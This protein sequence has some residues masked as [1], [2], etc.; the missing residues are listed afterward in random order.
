MSDPLL[1]QSVTAL[2]DERP[3]LEDFFAALGLSPPGNGTPL[4]RFLRQVPAERLAEFSLDHDQ[5]IAQCLAFIERME[6][7]GNER[8]E[9]VRRVTVKAGLD[10]DGRREQHDLHLECG[11]VVAIVGPTGSGKSRLLADIECLAQRDTPSGRQ[12]LLDGGLPDEEKR[13]GGEHQLVA[14]LSQNMNFVMDVTVAAFL[15]LHA[16]SRLVTDIEGCIDRIFRTAVALAGE[17]FTRKT[18]I[19]SLSGGQSRALM[20]ADVACLSSSPIVLIDEIENAGVDRHR[21]L[22]LLVQ[23]EKI[24]LIATH[25]PLLAL[26]AGRRVVIANGAIL[27]ILVTTNGERQ[28][29]DE[30]RTI[31]TRLHGLRERIRAGER[32]A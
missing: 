5:L 26:T 30:L 28:R 1:A 29:C 17:P 21:A 32:I 24:V 6:K 20:I 11:E 25:D 16:E 4:A 12:V 14:Q 15:R 7:F 9:A 31:E 19:T 10:K 23:K 27:A 22:E 3:Y 2:I 8:P 13:L 18:P